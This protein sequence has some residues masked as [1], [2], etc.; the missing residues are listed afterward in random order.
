MSLA[1]DAEF[2]VEARSALLDAIEALE[3]QRDALILI[4]AQAIYLHTGRAEVNLAETTKDSDLSVDPR[5][6]TDHPLIEDAMRASGF[7][8]HLDRPQPGIWFSQTGV[9]VDLMVPAALAGPGGRRGGRIPPHSSKATRRAVGLE[10]AM[11][12]HGPMEITALDPGDSRQVTIKVAG[13]AALLVAKLHKLHERHET[14]NR[15]VDKDAHDIYR[16]LVAIDTE[17]L[18]EGIRR[19]THDQLTEP[20]TRESLRYLRDLFSG[21]TAVGSFMAGRAESLVGVP[22]QV[23]AATAVLAND[24]LLALG[25]SVE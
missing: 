15:L 17:T 14:P 10:A 24:L 11:V 5:R 7:H 22:A 13:P 6:L 25:A 9:P 23:S 20:V 16:L 19:L 18:A 4:G 8:H 1:G 12:D 3:A 2:L 21:P